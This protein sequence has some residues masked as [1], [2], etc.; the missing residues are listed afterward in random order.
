MNLGSLLSAL[1]RTKVLEGAFSEDYE[2]MMKQATKAFW[3]GLGV[4][5]LIVMIWISL[6]PPFIPA[7]LTR[8]SKIEI[9]YDFLNV[10]FAKC[11]S[12]TLTKS[13]VGNFRIGPIVFAQRSKI[14][15][16]EIR[17]KYSNEAFFLFKH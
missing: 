8:H 9:R 10:G 7:I 11:L 6:Y 12:Q 15:D 17:A 14:S 5:T 3:A 4:F 13:R 16:I 1:P 2:S